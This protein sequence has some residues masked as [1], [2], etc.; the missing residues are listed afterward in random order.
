MNRL[1]IA[2]AT[3]L[4]ASY[5]G[6]CAL[7]SGTQ[8][9]LQTDLVAISAWTDF[10]QPAIIAYGKLGDCSPAA[11]QVV[12]C[13]DHATW[14]KTQAAAAAAH[15]AIQA[16]G[17]MLAGMAPDTGQIAKAYDAVK[18]AEAIFANKPATPGS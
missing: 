1:K 13:K 12:V 14:L 8:T 9:E 10:G 5:V 3:F 18:A 17:P 7:F 6:G 2:A 16:A 15:E 4:A 11:P